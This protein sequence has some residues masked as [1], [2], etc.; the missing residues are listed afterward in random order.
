MYPCVLRLIGALESQRCR[1][2]KRRIASAEA[3]LPRPKPAAEHTSSAKEAL[4]SRVP[5]PGRVPGFVGRRRI[6]RKRNNRRP[7]RGT[8][9]KMRNGRTA[10]LLG[11]TRPASDRR[12][13]PIGSRAAPRL[14]CHPP[15]QSASRFS[16]PS[17]AA[18]VARRRAPP[19]RPRTTAHAPWRHRCGL[20]CIRDLRQRSRPCPFPGQVCELQLFRSRRG[21]Y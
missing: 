4:I 9:R 10:P 14:P 18:L 15:V 7:V 5:A 13:G 19:P 1:A 8:A 12:V 3:V 11:R 17:T 20:P 21:I 6:R 16:L 2:S